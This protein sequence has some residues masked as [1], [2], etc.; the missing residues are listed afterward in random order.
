MDV[1]RWEKHWKDFIADNR[2]EIAEVEERATV[3]LE[4]FH[5]LDDYSCSL[6]SGTIVGKIWKR[7]QP[8]GGR[9]QWWLGQYLKSE[10]PEMIDIVWRE[11]HVR[12]PLTNEPE[13]ATDDYLDA[14]KVME[15]LA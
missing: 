10:D 1:E 5:K 13:L 15:A 11:L 14:L 4:T 9:G 3:T 7:H 8:F 6:P 12:H 2:V